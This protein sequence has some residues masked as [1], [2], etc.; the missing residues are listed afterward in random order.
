MDAALILTGAGMSI[1]FIST[2]GNG[3]NP[4]PVARGIMFLV[5]VTGLISFLLARIVRTLPLAIIASFL[6]TD[7]LSV[8]YGVRSLN[9][10]TDPYAYEAAMMF[11]IIFV[12][13]TGPTVLLSSI[14][15]GRLA[16]RFWQKRIRP[17]SLTAPS[18][19]PVSQPDHHTEK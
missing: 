10:S 11:P 18:P 14:G 6:I 5:L 13:A 16:G 19:A 4:V 9:S 8:L 3:Q 17:V 2:D 7:M 1:L 12:V 15:F